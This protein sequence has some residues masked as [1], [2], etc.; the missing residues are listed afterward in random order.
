MKQELKNFDRIDLFNQYHSKTNPFIIL[1]TKIDVTNIYNKC[2]DYYASIG[3]FI[4]LAANKIDNFKYRY[5]DGKF[6]KYDVIRPN[7][8][9]PFD[10]MNIGF[11]TCDLKD[12]YNEFMNEYKSIKQKFISNHKCYASEEEDEVWLSCVPW[13]S[14]SSLV[15]PFDKNIT[16]P[17]FLWDKFSFE[18]DKCYIDLMI[19]VHHGFMDGY[20]ISLFLKELNNIIEN[21]D[22]LI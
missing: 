8:T 21:I 20:H 19:M 10:D 17:Q 11:F 15:T 13:F 7:F 3:Y 5:K 12:N 22:E 4:T 1:T 16:V 14:F 9:E 6:C 2:K 18:N